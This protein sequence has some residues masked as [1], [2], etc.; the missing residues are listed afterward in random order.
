MLEKKLIVVRC[1]SGT[2]GT[3]TRRVSFCRSWRVGW[4]VGREGGDYRGGRSGKYRK[5]VASHYNI[6]S[7]EWGASGETGRYANCDPAWLRNI[8]LGDGRSSVS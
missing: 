1:I 5:V 2:V 3:F 6:R 4:G 8:S 7:G